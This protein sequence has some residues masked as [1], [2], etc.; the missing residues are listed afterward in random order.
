VI[1]WLRRHCLALPHATESVQWESLV[2]KVAGKMFAVAPL[3]P[4]SRYVLT[5][6]CAPE[7]FEEITE[8]VGIDPAP[9]L[10]RA[11]WIALES[12]EVVT[13][14][15]LKALVQAS[16]DLVFAKLSKKTRE[17]LTTG[18]ARR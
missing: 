2:F 13:H 12:E 9:Y 10:A 5:I 1:E 6:K 16:Y 7:Q 3:E 4:N 14:A 11:K 8:R 15:E 18:R 17:Q